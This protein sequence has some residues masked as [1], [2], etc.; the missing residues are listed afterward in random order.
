MADKE[1]GLDTAHYVCLKLE[2]LPS[3]LTDIREASEALAQALVTTGLGSEYQHV[4]VQECTLADVVPYLARCGD[5]TKRKAALVLHIDEFQDSPSLTVLLLRAIRKFNEIGKETVIL[6]VCTGLFAP[7][8]EVL[9]VKHM[10]DL[11]VIVSL[12]YLPPD[13]A[14]EVVR[15]AFVAKCQAS[16]RTDGHL[17]TDINDAPAALRYLVED[18]LGWALVAVQIGALLAFH[19]GHIL[20]LHNL[21]AAYLGRIETEIDAYLWSHYSPQSFKNAFGTGEE[22]LQKLLV[23]AMS[24]HTVCCSHARPDSI[25]RLDIPPAQPVHSCSCFLS[26]LFR[27]Q[28]T[29]ARCETSA[30]MA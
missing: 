4:S 13:H 21:T 5:M 26:S 22:G 1:L 11:P 12:H 23:L 20:E 7:G 16:S 25:S 15:N 27:S 24:P 14:W 9:M 29:A 19:I 8:I 30:G 6:P 10:S 2:D 17:P 28:S 3:G 18:T